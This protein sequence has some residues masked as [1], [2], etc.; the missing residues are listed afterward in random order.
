MPHPPVDPHVLYA[1]QMRRSTSG[2]PQRPREIEATRDVT[3]HLGATAV[4][5]ALEER[6]RQPRA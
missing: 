5:E 4:Q 6:R 3:R 1:L 2:H